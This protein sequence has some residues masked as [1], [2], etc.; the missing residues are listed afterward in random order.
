MGAS[1]RLSIVAS[2]QQLTLSCGDDFADFSLQPL[3]NHGAST[4]FDTFLR[5]QLLH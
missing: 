1:L 5:Y 4:C 3:R 2:E